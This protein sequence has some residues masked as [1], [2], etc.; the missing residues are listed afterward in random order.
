MKKLL[1]IG[2]LVERGGPLRKRG[3]SELFHQFFFREAR[4]H[5]Y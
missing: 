2:G 1:K 4:F 3:V 5:Y